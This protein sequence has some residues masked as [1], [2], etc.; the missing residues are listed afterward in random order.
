MATYED[1]LPRQ[2][3]GSRTNSGSISALAHV[4]FSGPS[5]TVR[6]RGKPV[7]WDAEL[8]G[9]KSHRFVVD[10]SVCFLVETW[11]AVLKLDELEGK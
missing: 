7:V 10:P 8:P 1:A 11:S 5:I 9:V 2:V 4:A 6:W 3:E